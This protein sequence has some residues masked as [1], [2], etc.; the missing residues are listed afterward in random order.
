[1]GTDNGVTDNKY[2]VAAG[3]TE[4]WILNPLSKQRIKLSSASEYASNDKPYFLDVCASSTGVFHAVELTKREVKNI[5]LPLTGEKRAISRGPYSFKVNFVQIFDSISGQ[6]CMTITPPGVQDL[7]L[8]ERFVNLDFE[9][10]TSDNALNYLLNNYEGVLFPCF[11][12]NIEQTGKLLVNKNKIFYDKK[13]I[14]VLDEDIQ[15]AL[16]IDAD[17]FIKQVRIKNKELY[18]QSKFF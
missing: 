12:G 6:S 1:M 5:K 11:R 16:E 7:P 10:Q 13:R 9:F 8:E 15:Y 4:I 18:R 17:K 2:I 14:T 3:K